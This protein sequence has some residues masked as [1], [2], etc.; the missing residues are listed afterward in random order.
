MAVK[1]T[2]ELPGVWSGRLK[3]EK[4][5]EMSVSVPSLARMHSCELCHGEK[6]PWWVQ[7]MA[8][9]AERKAVL[10]CT[11]LFGLKD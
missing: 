3:E 7:E 5:A 9:D 4:L 11:T 1:P 6:S 2:A 10:L 8:V